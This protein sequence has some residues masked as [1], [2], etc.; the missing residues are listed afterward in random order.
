MKN[1]QQ[2]LTAEMRRNENSFPTSTA[3]NNAWLSSGKLFSF[4]HFGLVK[5]FDVGYAVDGKGLLSERVSGNFNGTNWGFN[6][7]FR[8]FGAFKC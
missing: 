7:I 2:K 8:G 1:E 6:R 5:L 3:I 4:H